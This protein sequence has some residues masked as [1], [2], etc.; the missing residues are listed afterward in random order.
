MNGKGVIFDMDGVLV[1]SYQAHY[2]SWK[3]MAAAHGVNVTE[4]MFREQFG[5]TS[6]EIVKAWWGHVSEQEMHQWDQEKEE[7]YRKLILADFP[8]MDGAE[9]LLKDLHKAGFKLAIGSSGPPENVEVVRQCLREEG[10]DL[11]DAAVT[12]FE[13]HEGKPHPEVFLKAASKLGLQPQQCCVVEDAPVGVEAARRAG[14][15]VVAILGTVPREKLAKADIVVQS[16]REVSP[17]RI[18]QLID[19]NIAKA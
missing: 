7:A 13:V 10:A 4:Q 16:L 3:I 5:R 12:G 6:R 19:R 15:A 14:T 11:F 8:A 2:E 9:D 18:G 1:N 17:E